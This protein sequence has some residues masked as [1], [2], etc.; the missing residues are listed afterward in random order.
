MTHGALIRVQVLFP[1][2]SAH[3]LQICKKVTGG[4]IKVKQKNTVVNLKK[5]HDLDKRLF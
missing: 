4:G 5:N 2:E 1:H 3:W